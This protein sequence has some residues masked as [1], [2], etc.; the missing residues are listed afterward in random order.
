M[1]FI[2]YTS[3]LTVCKGILYLVVGAVSFVDQLH[4][5]EGE[6]F[7]SVSLIRVFAKIS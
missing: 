2:T 6:G 7:V 3:S 5:D 1:K 4:W